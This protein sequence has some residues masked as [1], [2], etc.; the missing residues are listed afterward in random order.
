M[1]KN[2][3]LSNAGIENLLRFIQTVLYDRTIYNSFV[4]TRIS[5]CSNQK[6]ESSMK[7][8]PDP[9]IANQVILRVHFQYYYYVQCCQE[10]IPPILFSNLRAALWLWIWF[11][12]LPSSLAT[13]YENW[14]SSEV[15]RRMWMGNMML[16]NQHH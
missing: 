13:K 5:I 7:L 14:K 3:Y 10:E 8:T 11:Y 1:F 15:K 4:I 9:N 2:K 12:Q 16:G 6:T